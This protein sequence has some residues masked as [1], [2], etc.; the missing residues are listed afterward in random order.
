M[1]KNRRTKYFVYGRDIQLVYRRHHDYVI[2]VLS[3]ESL[4][5]EVQYLYISLLGTSGPG[6]THIDFLDGFF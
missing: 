1:Q 2:P 5:L 6:D 4:G 3:S